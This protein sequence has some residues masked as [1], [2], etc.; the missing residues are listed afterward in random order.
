MES[1]AAELGDGAPKG[2]SGI[3]GDSGDEAFTDPTPMGRDNVAPS[4]RPDCAEE[5]PEWA[6]VAP[7]GLPNGKHPVPAGRVAA[8]EEED[9]CSGLTPVLLLWVAAAVA[10][11]AEEAAALLPI[12]AS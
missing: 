7:G 2:C 3:G 10:G 9:L 12:A 11:M 4:C 8:D 6:V 1:S 5:V